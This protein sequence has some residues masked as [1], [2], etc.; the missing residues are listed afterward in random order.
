M[1][2]AC[3]NHDK[4]DECPEVSARKVNVR[5]YFQYAELDERMILKW[6]FNK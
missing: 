2:S 1:D 5:E 4:D 6:F 3:S